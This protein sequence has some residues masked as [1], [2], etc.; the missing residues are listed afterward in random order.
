MRTRA[1]V[2]AELDHELDR[3][4]RNDGVLVVAYADVVGLKAVNDSAGHRA[5]DALSSAAW[6]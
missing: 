5:G 4:R 6:R 3:C 2:L 1:A